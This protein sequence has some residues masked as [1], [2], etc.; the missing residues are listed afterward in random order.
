MRWMPSFAHERRKRVRWAADEVD[1]EDCTKQMATGEDGNR[2]AADVGP[3]EKAAE[4]AVLREVKRPS[5]T[6][7]NVPARTRTIARPRQATVRRSEAAT[8][9]A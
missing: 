2:D 6:C 5:V 8:R 9:R 4:V 1:D 7:P 3:Y